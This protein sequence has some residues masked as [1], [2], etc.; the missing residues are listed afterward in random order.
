M[1]RLTITLAV[2]VTGAY[3][4]V[5]CAGSGSPLTPAADQEMAARL[6]PARQTHTQLW[7][8]YDVLID[9]ENR[10]AEIIPDRLA[11][12]TVNVVRFM[13]GSPGCM[14][15]QILDVT[16]G[17][18]F[19]D[20]DLHVTLRH[21]FPGSPQ[22]NGY[23]VR[24]VFMGDASGTLAYNSDLKYPV[25]GTDQF[26][27]RDPDGYTRWFNFTEFSTGGMPLFSYTQG[28]MAS[29]GFDGTATLCPYRYF[30]D[31]LGAQQDLWDFLTSTDGHGVFSCTGVNTRNYCLR[32]PQ[33]TGLEFGYAILADWEGTEPEYHPSN[34]VEAVACRVVD[35]SDVHYPD[36]TGNSGSLI[37]DISLF[38]WDY[39]SSTI[40]IESTVLSA[41]AS[42]DPAPIAT[43]G[44]EHYSTYHVEIPA[45]NVTGYQNQEYWVIAEYE[46]FDYTNNFGT[47]NEAGTDRLAAFFRYDLPVDYSGGWA[48]TWG[49]SGW[50]EAY[51]VAVDGSGTVYVTGNFQGTVDFNP[52]GGD[53]HTSHGYR[54]V[55]LSKFDSKGNFGWARTWGGPG[56]P[57]ARGVAVDGSGNVYVT[58]SFEGTVD[59]DPDGGDPHT[60][61]GYGDVFLSK[62]DSSGNFEWA[63]VWGGSDYDSGY[64][65]ADDGSGSVFVTGAFSGAVDFDPGYSEDR[66]TSNGG[67]DVFL[68][69]F[70]STGDFQWARTWGGPSYEHGDSVAADGSGDVYVTGRFRD[71]VDFNPDGGDPHTS[72]GNGDA[73]LSKF[74]PSGNF[75]WARTWG[76]SW[77][78]R[79]YGVAADDSGNVYVTGIFYYTVD[80]NPAGG[81]PHTSNGDYDAFLSKFDSSGNFEWARTW[82]GSESD[83][84]QGVAADGS[85]S[86]YATG[87][88]YGTVDFNPSG[89]DPHTSNGGPDVF[90]SK[91]DSSGSFTW[92]RSWGAAHSDVGNGVAAD[93]T[94]NVYVTGDFD[95]TVDF[96]PSGP[97][98]NDDPDEHASNGVS[99]AFLT[100]HLSNGC[101]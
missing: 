100:R 69:K 13:N 71:T 68:S 80:F 64:G 72:N 89:G 99:D 41:V 32:F 76:G 29:P 26:M 16:H 56:Q 27:L 21:P 92:G 82:G 47:P 93:G 67:Y 70:D 91:F 1:A 42:F 77:V 3:V 22:F 51:G 97:P 38:G 85:G 25:L 74:D 4:V 55:F 94:G 62:F 28:R 57:Y 86:I 50:D 49:G 65:V 19:V 33:T 6:S 101:W 45:D 37:L 10:V 48:R 43:G 2:L 17:P 30:A 40:Y 84:G 46:A 36:S 11:M 60:S 63:R 73:F 87:F 81:D 61:N 34:A 24:G 54:D 83:R 20:I 52:D 79:G 8:Y 53:T 35:Y 96:A 9:I 90:L 58:G 18:D 44:G 78:D 5:G 95:D 15:I 14:T 66:H 7:G 59:F 88:F 75:M 98:C 39:Q 31:G 12:F 23:D